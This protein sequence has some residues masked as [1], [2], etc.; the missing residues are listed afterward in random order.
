MQYCFPSMFGVEEALHAAGQAPH[1][2][3]QLLLVRQ[4]CPVGQLH[5]TA[6]PQLLFRAVWQAAPAQVTAVDS[7]THVV[8]ATQLPF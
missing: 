6:W 7:G 5:A 8:A 1:G 2:I 3:A 4:S